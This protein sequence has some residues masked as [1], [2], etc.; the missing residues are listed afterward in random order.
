MSAK[1][2]ALITGGSSGIGKA[3]G[4]KLAAAGYNVSLIARRDT[5]LA[6]AAADM[7]RKGQR[8][9]SVSRF[10]RPMFPTGARPKPR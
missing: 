5:L 2:H 9:I 8:P 10:I 3:L 6:S 1:M 7:R 4:V